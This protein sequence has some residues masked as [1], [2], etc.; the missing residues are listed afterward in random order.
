MCWQVS[1]MW[2]WKILFSI[3]YR[4]CLSGNEPLWFLSKSLNVPFMQVCDTA[5]HT[6]VE[7]SMEHQVSSSSISLSWG[8]VSHRGWLANKFLG[9]ACLYHAWPCECWGFKLLSPCLPSKRSYTPSQLP[10]PPPSF[11]EG[12]FFWIQCFC[13]QCRF[14][15]FTGLHSF[16]E[17]VIDTSSLLT[18]ELLATNSYWRRRIIHLWRFSNKKVSHVQWVASHPCTYEQH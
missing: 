4:C 6:Q 9:S 16:A 10:R 12:Q 17:I 7:T 1:P 14:F 11:F 18:K 15:S 13:I 8:R 3:S 2:A 5:V